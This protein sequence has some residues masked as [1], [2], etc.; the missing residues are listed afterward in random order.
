MARDILGVGAP[1][2]VV[3]AR[4]A[5]IHGLVFRASAAG[6][7]WLGLL[8]DHLLTR[9]W[10]YVEVD[11]WHTYEEILNA[12]K[13]KRTLMGVEVGKKLAS[14]ATMTLDA[15]RQCLMPT[16]RRVGKLVK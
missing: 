15:L 2:S 8:D 4:K 9:V 3:M 6:Q 10:Q 1:D 5:R 7:G 13:D 14:G 12:F 16:P 11:E